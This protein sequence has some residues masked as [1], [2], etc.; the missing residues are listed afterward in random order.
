MIAR[1]YM[2]ALAQRVG[3]DNLLT[4]ITDQSRAAVGSAGDA[5]W[6]ASI[7]LDVRPDRAERQSGLVIMAVQH[8]I[9]DH[10]ESMP[11]GKVIELRGSLAAEMRQFREYMATYEEKISTFAQIDDEDRAREHLEDMRSQSVD[12]PL[13]ALEE[14]IRDLRMPLRMS[15]ELVLAGGAGLAGGQAV[16][17]LGGTN[18]GVLGSAM[19]IAAGAVY[20]RGRHREAVRSEI[21]E[22]PVGYLY[23]LQRSSQPLAQIDRFVPNLR[24]GWL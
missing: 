19:L 4:P 23:Q 20:G 15:W 11:W 21:R 5:E 24:M 17:A 10:L 16:E 18:P 7:L 6:L 22:S 1:A 8:A 2:A 13:H 12:D 3:I 14:R 9:P